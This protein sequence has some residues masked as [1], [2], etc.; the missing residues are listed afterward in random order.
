MASEAL[1][2]EKKIFPNG[3]EISTSPYRELY[4]FKPYNLSAYVF[5]L[6]A[7]SRSEAYIYMYYF[8]CGGVNFV[9]LSGLACFIT[10]W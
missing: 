5:V 3:T 7:V 10:V 9:E 8:S 1:K 2:E 6:P 4:L